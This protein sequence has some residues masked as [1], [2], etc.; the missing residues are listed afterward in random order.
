M[1]SPDWVPLM[2]RAAALVT[3]AGGMTSHA[4][5][6]SREMGLPCI[7][8]A[9]QATSV[10]KNGMLV[11]VDATAGRVLEGEVALKPRATQT[12]AI[13]SPGGER[14]VTATKV[15]VNLGEPERAREVALQ[16]VDG[17][18][19][20]RA[21]FMLLSALQGVHPR[22]LIEEGRADEFVDRMAEQLLVFAEAFSP[23][24]VIYRSTDF[25]TNE[26]RGLAGGEQYEPHEE[27]P[28]IGLRGAYRYVRDPAPFKL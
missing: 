17:V 19:L 3:D 12:A 28:M 4:A 9:R 27:N 16:Q 23:R 10:L 21:E 6:V 20:L 11:T 26:F 22:K 24:P 5:I 15:M 2:R 25:R 1:T 18:G 7:V 13:R 8:G 14:T